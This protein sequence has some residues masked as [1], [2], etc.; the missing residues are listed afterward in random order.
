LAF[1]G[2]NKKIA[3]V[4]FGYGL[5][6][7]YGPSNTG[8]SSILDAMDF[9]LGRES[10]MTELPEH[11]GYD[12][13]VLGIRF[14]D[15]E[16][17]SLFRNIK[18]GNY[19]CLEGLTTGRL[20][21]VNGKVLRVGKGTKKER[22]LSSF[23]FEKLGIAEKKLKV[24]KKNQV[25]SLTL[26]NSIKL[27]IVE[28][29]EIQKKGSPYFHKGFTKVTEEE[30]RLNLFLTGVD[31]SNLLPDVIEKVAISNAARIEVL[32]ELVE[33]NK[34][35][36]VENGFEK[37][38]YAEVKQQKE[39]LYESMEKSLSIIQHE[40][41]KLNT[42]YLEKRERVREIENQKDRLGEVSAMLARFDIL[43]S[44]YKTDIARLENIIEGG[45]LIYALPSNSCP[46][47]GA[48]VGD[49]LTHE[50]CDDDVRQTI[51][52]AV[53]EIN[54]ITKLQVDLEAT[55][56][57]L[58]NERSSLSDLLVTLDSLT[59]KNQNDIELAKTSIEKK[60]LSYKEYLDTKDKI[61]K[62]VSLSEQQEAL[63]NKLKDIEAKVSAKPDTSN[64]KAPAKLSTNS[65]YKLSKVVQGLLNDWGYSH[66][67]DVHFD[68]E[69]RDFVFDGKHRKGN[70]KGVRALMHAAA[71]LG[72]M[73]YQDNENSFNHFGFV[74]LDSPL[75]AYEEP[76]NEEDDLSD[77]D[78][79]QRF[80][81]VLATWK[82]NQVIVIENKKSIPEKY[83]AG[84]Q[85]IEFTRKSYG[86]YGFFPTN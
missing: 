19:I 77:T 83:L 37:Y 75:L 82:R 3:K 33:E 29:E 58:N 61:N 64:D 32:T 20:D 46:Y 4:E 39:R 44:Q 23:I 51:D 1:T 27:A 26:R 72:L 78:I 25:N 28:E 18:G 38:D 52:A 66:C 54:K 6:I 35:E 24:N 9:M 55:L 47:C 41:Q 12:Q 45:T 62:F 48:A 42:L 40:E 63:E 53:A 76:E 34:N 60:R 86:R 15:T 49:S 69:T 74:V 85:V 73:K 50:K 79:N 65:L 13:V 10:L 5:N 67:N 56:L 43:R 30:S 36:I 59:E 17:Y 31:D 81:N 22:S 21:S 57:S 16:E 70:G 8:K 68:K 7:I 14:S 2:P 11:D 71:T 84:D 80:F